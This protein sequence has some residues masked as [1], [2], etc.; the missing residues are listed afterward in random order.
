MGPPRTAPDGAALNGPPRLPVIL[1][2]RVAPPPPGGTERS[3]SL[4]GCNVSE[5]AGFDFTRN[6][7]IIFNNS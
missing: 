1:S 5:V 4:V 7:G 2:R 6:F 3:E